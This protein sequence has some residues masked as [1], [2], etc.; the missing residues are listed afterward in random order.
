ML[1]L[2]AV[3]APATAAALQMTDDSGNTVILERHARRI[4][5]LAP[6][7]TE[8]LFAAGAGDRLVGV[9]EY[10]NYPEA[11]RAIP[12][13]G[14]YS[15]IDV[16][17][18]VTLAPDL[19]IGWQSGNRSQQLERLREL[20]VML[21]IT[22]PRRLEDVAVDLERFGRLAGTTATAQRASRA[23][24]ARLAALQARYHH[25]PPVPVF[26]QIWNQP[27]M[28]VNGEHL[29]SDVMRLCGGANV[30]ADLPLLAQAVDV[31]AVLVADPEAI[32]ASGMAEE[33]PEWLDDWRRWRGLRAV[34]RDNLFF[35]PPDLIQRHAPRI[36]DGAARLC[37]AL[38]TARTRR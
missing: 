2:L 6:H 22:E 23:F 12:R 18:I 30:F 11:A 10:S 15:S 31:E 13:V 19:V 27:L 20:G 24:R 9:V 7:I 21:Y 14:G 37:A 8:V 35:V 25:R 26:Y 17:R 28:T 33:R 4:V 1:V 5:S 38:D 16:E 3:A 34:R 36:L 32:V 29:I